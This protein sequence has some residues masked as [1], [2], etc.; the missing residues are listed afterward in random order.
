[1][2]AEE[3][4]LN[5]RLRPIG[6]Y[7][8]TR[9]LGSGAT[10]RVYLAHDP[11]SGNDVA[12][13]LY[14]RDNVRPKRA[15]TRRKVFA[16]EARLVGRLVH[17]NIVRV[18]DS[19][20]SPEGAYIVSE[21]LR[22]AE[23]LSIHTHLA[24]RLPQRRVAELLFA[25]ARALDYAHRNGIVHRDV[26]ASNI[27]LTAE[28]EPKLIDFGVAM[29]SSLDTCTVTGLVGSPS[30]MAPEQIRDGT[31]TPRSDIYSLGVVGYELLSARLPFYGQNLSHLIHQIIY[32]TPRPLSRLRTNVSPI[33]ERIIG[34]AM[35]KDPDRRFADARVMAAQLAHAATQIEQRS[36][37]Q[38]VHVRF[39][40]ARHLPF[41]RDFGYREVWEAVNHGD[42]LRYAEGDLIA[43]AKSD[44][45]VLYIVV[46]GEVALTRDGTLVERLQRGHTFGEL[47]LLAGR[48]RVTSARATL[49]TQIMRLDSEQL[50]ATSDACQL[51]FHKLFNEALL[52]RLTGAGS[53]G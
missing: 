30:Y 17:S 18:T 50:A 10:S 27:L 46:T 20:E 45:R 53:K 21:Y 34:K 7:V 25:C 29:F 39:D 49:P 23:P 15:N 26:K 22:G 40:V 24:G 47:A 52:Q 6:R 36:R 51:A 13:K 3:T 43:A 33:L 1:M 5:A 48:A 4:G 42:W 38:D 41:F 37:Q 31:A 35:E 16:N 19:G 44:E 2:S 8:I 32:G 11:A 9:E 28:G 14:Y 12:L